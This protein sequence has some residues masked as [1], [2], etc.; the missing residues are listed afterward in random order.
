M[1]NL[2]TTQGGCK[3]VQ[4]TDQAEHAYMHSGGF[5]LPRRIALYISAAVI[6]A[7]FAA[8]AFAGSKVIFQRSNKAATSVNIVVGLA[9]GHAYRVEIS[10]PKKH[11]FVVNG[12][13][14]YRY[15]AN[16]ML[17][18]ST[19]DVKK[20]GKTPGSFVIKQPHVPSLDQW[21]LGA[22][23]SVTTGRGITVRVVDLGKRP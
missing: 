1:A 3:R 6:A 22:D 2:T 10:S 7:A 11:S 17:H 16:K 23:V 18:S 8:P 20:K 13:Q 5:P 12:F 19:S 9:P 4:L 15:V 21:I 14:D